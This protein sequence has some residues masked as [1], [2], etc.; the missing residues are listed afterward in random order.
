MYEGIDYEGN[1]VRGEI[2]YREDGSVW[3]GKW[4]GN[5]SA[6]I[7]CRVDEDSVKKINEK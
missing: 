2:E 1:I 7:N 4:K 5:K 6:W 3:I